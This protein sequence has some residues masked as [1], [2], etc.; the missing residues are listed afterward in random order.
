MHRVKRAHPSAR[1]REKMGRIRRK[2]Q[3]MFVK[4]RTARFLKSQSDARGITVGFTGRVARLARVHHYGETDQVA[5]GG[6]AYRYPARKLL[7]FTPAD[8]QIIRDRLLAYLA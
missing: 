5:P 1:L 3:A 4:L 8:R 2:P 6:P 7:G